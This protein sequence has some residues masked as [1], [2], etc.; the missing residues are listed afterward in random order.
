MSYVVAQQ[1]IQSKSLVYTAA[2]SAAVGRQGTL[3]MLPKYAENSS[4]K[5][6][7]VQNMDERPAGRS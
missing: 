4:A 5:L 3:V 6:T 1:M 2:E 7:S